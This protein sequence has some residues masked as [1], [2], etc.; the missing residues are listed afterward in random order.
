MAETIDYWGHYP[1][2][3][4]QYKTEA[5]VQ[6]GLRAWA[7]FIPGDAKTSN[8]P[9]AVFE[10]HLTNTSSAR[11]TGTL[12]FSFPGFAKHHTR[13]EVIGWPNLPKKIELPEPHIERRPAPAGLSGVWVEDKAWGMSYVLAAL[14]ESGARMGGELGTD[15]MK[16]AEIEK[17]LPET[18]KPMMTA[19]R[20]WR[21]TSAWSRGKR[22]WCALILAWYA[23]EWEGNGIPGSGGTR[24]ITEAP[25]GRYGAFDHGKAFHAHVCLP[26]RQCGRGGELPGPQP[27]VAA[28]NGSLPG[29]R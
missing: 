29:S 26:V 13:D 22:K 3:D 16:W 20:R 19:A 23:P 1:I 10:I 15:G 27:S 11:Q 25:G 6:V 9:G 28:G 7:P 21:W 12:A 2:V 18:G 8:T 24:I 4:M 14:E 5:P 17:G